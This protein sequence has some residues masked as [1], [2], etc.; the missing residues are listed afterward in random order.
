MALTNQM[1]KIA[2]FRKNLT[3][4]LPREPGFSANISLHTKRLLNINKKF[5]MRIR[6]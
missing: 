2:R 5:P 6:Y 1:N 3:P 4:T